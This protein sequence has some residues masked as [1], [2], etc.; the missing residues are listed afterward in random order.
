MNPKSEADRKQ[1]TA[2]CGSNW[3]RAHGQK[4]VDKSDLAKEILIEIKGLKVDL[5]KL[6][7]VI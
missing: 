4:S 7:E 3:R 2:V 6:K 5:A 1:A